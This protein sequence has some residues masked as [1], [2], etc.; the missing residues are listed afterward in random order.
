MNKQHPYIKSLLNSLPSTISSSPSSY[1]PLFKS[2]CR[3]RGNSCVDASEFLLGFAILASDL[4]L[5][6]SAYDMD[7]DGLLHPDEFKMLCRVLQ[8]WA[9]KEEFVTLSIPSTPV[10]ISSFTLPPRLLSQ[11]S[12]RITSEMCRQEFQ[13]IRD[14]LTCLKSRMNRLGRRLM[15]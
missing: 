13:R 6:F 9:T 4:T 5:A 11:C 14:E 10:S 8:F 7:R 1:L 12:L 2:L 15:S 3:L